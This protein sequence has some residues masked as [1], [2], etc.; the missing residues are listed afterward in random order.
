MKRKKRRKRMRI[1]GKLLLP[2]LLLLA[3]LSSV[4]QKKTEPV[5]VIAGTVFRDPGFALP[6]AEVELVFETAADPKLTPKTRK[7]KQASDARGEFA[8]RVP[9]VEARYTLGVAAGGYTGQSK[10]VSVAGEERID[11][12][13]RLETASKK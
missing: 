10:T 13:F 3:A 2:F 5:A 8:F 4:A 6:G 11:V 1:G 12:I 7:W 9:A